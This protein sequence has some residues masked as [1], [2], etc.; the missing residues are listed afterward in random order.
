[1]SDGEILE[2]KELQEARASKNLS[3]PHFIEM[4]A[5]L[6]IRNQGSETRWNAN[7]LAK[8][9][10]IPIGK[11]YDLLREATAL[12]MVKEEKEN[13]TIEKGRKRR[14]KVFS[15][16]ENS[17]FIR[18]L[19]GGKQRLQITVD[20]NTSVR[21]F[22]DIRNLFAILESKPFR[23][24]C[25]SIKSTYTYFTLRKLQKEWK[26]NGFPKLRAALYSQVI[27]PMQTMSPAIRPLERTESPKSEAII[28]RDE[29]RNRRP[30]MYYR[31]R[32]ATVHLEF[33]N[34]ELPAP[35]TTDDNGVVYIDEGKWEL[36]P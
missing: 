2:F 4:L 21:T 15:L 25:Q 27:Q 23:I 26:R 28:L 30:P 7:P 32:Y 31:F 34:E 6:S 35:Y 13:A 20:R 33:K 3:R 18:F 9:L 8:Y 5:A 14:I 12:R 19:Q 29:G 1:M 16:V 10:R 36:F 22:D 17:I 24:S 11:T